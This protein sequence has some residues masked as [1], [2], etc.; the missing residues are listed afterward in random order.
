MGKYEYANGLMRLWSHFLS[1]NK[2]Y[3]V[4]HEEEDLIRRCAQV[5][6]NLIAAKNIK[7]ITLVSYGPGTKFK[8]KEG[9]L[10]KAFKK[11]GIEIAKVIYVD[12]YK[13]ALNK[14]SKEGR[15][16]LPNAIHEKIQGDIFDPSSRKRA[17]IVGAEVGTCFGLTPMNAEGFGDVMPPVSAIEKNLKGLRAQMSKGAHFIATYDHNTDKASIEKSYAGRSEHAKGLLSKYLRWSDEDL[18]DVDFVVKYNPRSYIAAHGFHFKKNMRFELGDG[19][20]RHVKDGITLW[21]QN[22]VK[23]PKYITQMVH[24]HSGFE[25][26]LPQKAEIAENGRMGYH[27]MTAV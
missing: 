19:R 21:F 24:E 4:L 15:K 12:K 9:E 25:Y 8:A 10:I 3:Y 7:T 5:S 2:E 13:S 1:N 6:A 11:A 17:G 18:R 20:S 23:L 22:S 14:S 16:L 27:H 26:L